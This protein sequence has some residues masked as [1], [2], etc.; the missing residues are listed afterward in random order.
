M[1]EARS[2]FMGRR[3]C[4]YLNDKDMFERFYKQHLSKRLLAGRVTND[5]VE[6]V[7]L[8]ARLLRMCTFH[9]IAVAVAS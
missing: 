5:G 9:V 8:Q 1:L 7:M 3:V 2:C 6:A 4:R